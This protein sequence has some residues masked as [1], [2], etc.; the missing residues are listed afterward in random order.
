M[1]KMKLKIRTSTFKE[2]SFTVQLQLKILLD[3]IPTNPNRI[4]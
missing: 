4:N 2:Q 1:I 3:L